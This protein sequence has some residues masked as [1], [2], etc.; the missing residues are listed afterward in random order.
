[1]DIVE[2]RE[3]LL[4][5]TKEDALAAMVTPACVY[6][7]GADRHHEAVQNQADRVETLFSAAMNCRGSVLRLAI[8]FVK[9][10]SNA[11][12]LDNDL[13]LSK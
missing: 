9:D 6:A 7:R 4:D 12:M 10:L 5:L 8:R 11:V 13:G 3:F 1:M 2:T